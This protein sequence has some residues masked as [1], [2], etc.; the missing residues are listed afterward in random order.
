MVGHAPLERI[1]LVRVQASE[2]R[3]GGESP[4]PRGIDR[5]EFEKNTDNHEPLAP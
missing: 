2:F 5:I 3:C 4:S 1:I